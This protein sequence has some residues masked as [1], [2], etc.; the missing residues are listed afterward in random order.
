MPCLT[1]FV[2]RLNLPLVILGRVANFESRLS[3]GFDWECGRE[4]SGMKLVL[5]GIVAERLT[6]GNQVLRMPFFGAWVRIP[7]ISLAFLLSLPCLY[8]LLRLFAAIFPAYLAA[9]LRVFP[10]SEM[11]SIEPIQVPPD[12]ED[13]TYF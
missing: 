2:R 1:V 3:A 12:S 11:K 13:L 5:R 10:I 6:R 9:S 4:V 7:S 8:S